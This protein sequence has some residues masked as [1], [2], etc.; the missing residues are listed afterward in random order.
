MR[1]GSAKGGA[2]S[3]RLHPAGLRIG[4][5]GV[6]TSARYAIYG[7][8]G[9]NGVILVTTI[10]RRTGPATVSFDTYISLSRPYARVQMMNWQQFA[11]YKRETYRASG[12]DM[13]DFAIFSPV[14]IE[15]MESGQWTDYQ[16]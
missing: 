11:E 10:R 4:I 5:A 1:S 14:E 7:S 9:A 6:R 8:R 12:R 13:E 2:H 15:M 16:D 3:V